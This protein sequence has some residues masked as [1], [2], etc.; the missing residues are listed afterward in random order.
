MARLNSADDRRSERTPEEVRQSSII[1]LQVRPTSGRRLAGD[2]TARVLSKIASE[3]STKGH[4][5]EEDER[6]QRNKEPG[7]TDS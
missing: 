5:S 1:A 2:V 7:N 4:D 3:E 6:N